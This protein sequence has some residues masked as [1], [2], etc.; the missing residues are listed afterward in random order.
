MSRGHRTE[1]KRLRAQVARLKSSD[2]IRR[3][4]LLEILEGLDEWETDQLQNWIAARA[5]PASREVPSGPEVATRRVVLRYPMDRK[6][7]P[8]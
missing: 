1:I 4:A 2:A 6:E 5:Y 3:A 8:F 7:S